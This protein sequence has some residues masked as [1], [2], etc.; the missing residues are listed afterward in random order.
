MIKKIT[1]T[2]F[3]CAFALF[4]QVNAQTE[5]GDQKQAAIKELITLINTDNKSADMANI[6]SQQMELSR[7]GTIRA[8]LDE[9]TDLNEAERKALEDALIEDFRKSTRR[10]Q[11][12]LMKKLD[13]DT[14]MDEIMMSVYGK[15]YTVEEIR[16]LVNFYKTPTGQKSIKLMT[17]TMGESMQL[18]QERLIPKI[19]LVIRELQEEDRKEIEEKINTKKP[20]LD[21]KAS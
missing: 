16:D 1:F 5:N 11:E 15:Y 6:I 9:R 2:L 17:V 3:L 20:R 14:M 7:A 8:I 12:R 4:T 10:F 13:F 18:V 19:P 21:R